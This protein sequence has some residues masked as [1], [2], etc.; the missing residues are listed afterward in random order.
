[1]YK[2]IR[3]N[4]HHRPPFCTRWRPR[5]ASVRLHTPPHHTTHHHRHWLQEA[6]FGTADKKQGRRDLKHKTHKK[7]QSLNHAR[8]DRKYTV[9]PKQRTGGG[10]RTSHLSVLYFLAGQNHTGVDRSTAH[11]CHVM[12]VIGRASLTLERLPWPRFLSEQRRRC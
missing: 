7:V 2:Q 1:M 10:R 6:F 4:R 5:P 12:H 8:K 3:F 9:M 11:A